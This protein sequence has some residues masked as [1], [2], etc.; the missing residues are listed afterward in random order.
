MPCFQIFHFY[1]RS[2]MYLLSLATFNGRK[3]YRCY[4][5]GILVLSNCV[6]TLCSPATSLFPTGNSFTILDSKYV[7]FLLLAIKNLIMLVTAYNKVILSLQY[8]SQNI[9]IKHTQLFNVT[10]FKGHIVYHQ[11]LKHQPSQ[12]SRKI[13]FLFYKFQFI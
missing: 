12:L 3:S 6:A 13:V 5:F 1:V 10:G 11:V 8:V 9:I 7:E 2:L 4:K